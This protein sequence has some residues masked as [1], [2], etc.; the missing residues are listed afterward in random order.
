MEQCFAHFGPTVQLLS[1]SMPRYKANLFPHLPKVFT[2]VVRID[3]S[4]S[5]ITR[6]V[7]KTGCDLETL[8]LWS[9]GCATIDCRLLE[10]R[11]DL[12]GL[13]IHITPAPPQDSGSIT[14]PYGA[15]IPWN[16]RV[17][18]EVEGRFKSSSYLCA[19]RSSHQLTPRTQVWLTLYF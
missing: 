12:G 7:G 1:F 3:I 8:N 5:Y 6:D 13:N 11:T 14:C 4:A 10:A 16:L 2:R 17:G 9:W 15:L 19:G 18:S